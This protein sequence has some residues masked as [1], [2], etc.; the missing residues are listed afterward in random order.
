M[1]K[2]DKIFN[3][4]KTTKEKLTA[5]E[6]VAAIGVVTSA[7]DSSLDEVDPDYIADIL[8]EFLEVFEEYSDDQML[9][10][11]DKLMA[12][13]EEDG[14]GALFNAA[15]SSLSEDFALD[16]YAAGVSLL[17]DEEEMIIP[18][19][20]MNLL[21]KLQEALGIEDDEATEVKAEVLA[22]FAE[23]ELED[24]DDE[25]L[26]DEPGFE[27]SELQ[28][29]ESPTKN[30]VVPIPVDTQRGG[31]VQAQEGLVSFSD[32]F[33]TLL[34]IDYFRLTPQQK[35]ELASVGHEEFLRSLLL[36]QY[37]PQG[38]V[39]NLPEAQVKH[40]KYIEDALDGA[41]FVLVDM[42][43]GSNLPKT[44]NNGTASRLDAYRGLLGFISGHFLY[45]VSS[46]RSFFDGETPGSIEDESVRIEESL[47]NFVD[48]IE[49][50]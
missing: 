6:A 2:Y 22:A 15:K 31:R 10:L 48:T 41:Y 50:T 29:Y 43:E 37:V 21:K 40:T 47:L 25:F 26:D 34:R 8:W 1:G 44:G 7:A 36:E 28:M 32:D 49:F 13:A 39:V 4:T 27:E 24:D 46:Q 3:S 38:I 33:G 20:K 14:V 45:I 30:F 11:L 23:E 18:K 19:G 12:I 5:Q 9:D 35:K 42:P 17:V 16:A